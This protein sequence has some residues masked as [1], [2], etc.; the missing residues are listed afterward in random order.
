MSTSKPFRSPSAVGL[1]AGSQGA[2]VA[3]L[4]E[5][6]SRFG[7]LNK[8][9][10]SERY[11]IL[12]THLAQL[13]VPDAE[14]GVFD[15]ATVTALRNYQRFIGMPATGQLDVATVAQMSMPRCGFPDIP[16]PVGISPFLATS[17]RWNVSNL[18]YGF[19]NYT[20]DLAQQQIERAISDALAL[21]SAVIPL[22]FT[23]TPIENNPDIVIEFATGNHGDAWPFD[24][25]GNVLAHAFFPPPNGGA[26]AGDAH[27]DDDETWTVSI[28]VPVEGKD[29]VSVAAHEFGH[30]LGLNHSSVAGALMYPFYTGPQRFL[31]ADDITGIQS[32]YG[33]QRLTLNV[34]MHPLGGGVGRFRINVKAINAG[35]RNLV[36]GDVIF[37]DQVVAPTNTDFE[38]TFQ[39]EIVYLYDGQDK[40]IIKPKKWREIVY[41]KAVV[42]APPYPDEPIKFTF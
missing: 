36:A 37:D 16:N 28:P 25:V 18:T 20:S 21:W 1:A 14:L 13:N 2:E 38:H 6:L 9:Q 42:H 7:Y 29:L 3:E 12:Y 31:H 17:T 8:K 23:L 4:Q 27:F 35:T 33:Q 15:E 41:P 24:G 40:P 19:R 34:Q 11:S 10:I 30:S 5:F 32:I 39:T 22:S 26:I